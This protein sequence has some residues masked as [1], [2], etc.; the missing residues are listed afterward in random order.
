MVYR[1]MGLARTLSKVAQELSKSDTLIKGWSAKWDWQKRV[2]AWDDFLDE[3]RREAYLTQVERMS[4]RHAKIA[5]AG[6]QGLQSI[7]E[8][9]ISRV[10]EKGLLKDEQTSDKA[11]ITMFLQ[12]T[13]KLGGLANVERKAMGL[14]EFMLAIGQMSDDQLE[15]LLVDLVT[16]AQEE[17]DSV[18][19][20][21]TG[22]AGPEG[23]DGGAEGG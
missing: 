15:S 19:D 4:I 20:E 9:F 3:Q 21:G 16:N 7:F 10:S 14:P 23:S 1:D 12:A 2:R 17:A 13:S 11:L 8:E 22:E 18:G 5:S 6:L